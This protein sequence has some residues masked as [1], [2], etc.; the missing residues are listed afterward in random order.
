MVS[1]A[2]FWNVCAMRASTACGSFASASGD[3]FVEH[4]AR[5]VLKEKYGVDASAV[6]AAAERLIGKREAADGQG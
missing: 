1:E 6:A 5:N 3:V 2:R 4:G